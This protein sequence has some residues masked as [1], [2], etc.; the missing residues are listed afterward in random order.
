MFNKAAELTYG[1]MGAHC[2]RAISRNR[3]R[4]LNKM[5]CKLFGIR[6]GC[7]GIFLF[8]LTG[9]PLPVLGGT[10]SPDDW[11]F[12]AEIYF[13]GASIGGT[14]ASGGD[15]DIGIDKLLDDLEMAFMGAFA[16][17]KDKWTL[18]V[19]L[20]YLDVSQENDGEITIPVGPRGREIDL[21][22]SAEVDM[23]SWV[24]TPQ[25]RYNLIENQKGSLDVLGGARYLWLDAKLKVKSSGPLEDREGDV[26]D[27]DGVWDAIV[28]VSGHL[29]LSEQ[30]YVPYYLDVGAG[31]TDLT[32]QAFAGIGYRFERVDAILGYRYIDWDFDDSP[33]FDDMNLSGFFL[34]AKFLF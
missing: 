8:L 34:G 11:K 14:T 2:S 27:S 24:I 4:G 21:T 33:V 9:F 26:S 6:T 15:I 30:W 7:V 16:A 20:I 23:K 13:W 19:D 32:W 10:D 28:G 18:A 3:R 29:N 5:R 12:G 17:R 1:V 22:G 31:Q 25:V